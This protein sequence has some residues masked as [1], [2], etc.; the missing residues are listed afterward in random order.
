MQQFELDEFNKERLE[1]YPKLKKCVELFIGLEGNSDR[2]DQIPDLI[3]YIKCMHMIEPR[4]FEWDDETTEEFYS[5]GHNSRYVHVLWPLLINHFNEYI[6]KILRALNWT[7][8]VQQIPENEKE[9][10]YK[11]V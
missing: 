5:W 7:H 9:W 11:E 6:D 4:V 10:F 2:P 8:W 3:Y 1:N